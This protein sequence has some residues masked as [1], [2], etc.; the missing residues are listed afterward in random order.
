VPL[1]KKETESLRNN[2]QAQFSLLEIDR[3]DVFELSQND[4]GGFEVVVG[5][6]GIADIVNQS[7]SFRDTFHLLKT[8]EMVVSQYMDERGMSGMFD[9]SKFSI[10]V[11]QEHILSN[12]TLLNQIDMSAEEWDSTENTTLPDG[13]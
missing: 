7:S 12:V 4:L 8:A 1:I 5:D 9:E 10:L 6:F 11:S 2:L 3:S 13:E